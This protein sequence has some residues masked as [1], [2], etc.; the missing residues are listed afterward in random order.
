MVPSLSRPVNISKLK[1]LTLVTDHYD[2]Y[3]IDVIGVI[4]D[5]K[6]PYEKAIEG[7]NHLISSGKTVIFLSNNPRPGTLTREKLSSWGVNPPFKVVTSGDIARALLST[8]FKDKRIYHLG[9]ERNEEITHSLNLH[10]VEDISRAD[11][12][13]LTAFLE[14]DESLSQHVPLL[15]EAVRLKLPVLCAN[16][17]KRA[18]HG[19]KIRLCAG[20][21]ADHLLSRGRNVI[22]TGKP[23]K[24]IFESLPSLFPA[25]LFEKKRMIM[26]GD[27]LETDIQGAHQFGIDSL[28]VLSGNTGKE[29]ERENK[30]LPVYIQENHAFSMSPRFYMD[31]LN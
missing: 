24:I 10:I 9:A 30:S 4:H 20:T 11:L 25:V 12:L 2:V 26:I 22:Y 21:L 29:L 18:P 31:Y 5:G 27:S 28:L 1:S 14:P 3:L 7:V 13:L 19:D 23:D 8:Q 16:P 15:E 6:N 17:D